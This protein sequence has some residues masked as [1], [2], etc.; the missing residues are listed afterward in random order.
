VSDIL[1]N[2]FSRNSHTLDEMILAEQITLPCNPY[3]H[4]SNHNLGDLQKFNFTLT[5]K[6][7]ESRSRSKKGLSLTQSAASIKTKN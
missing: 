7:S 6:Q 1:K 2:G 5:S 3:R 4:K